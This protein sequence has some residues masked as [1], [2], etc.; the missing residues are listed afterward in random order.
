MKR[1]TIVAVLNNFFRMYFNPRPR[2]EGDARRSSAGFT[3]ADFN[4]RPREEGDR[5]TAMLK[6][7][8]DDFNPRP[9]EEGDSVLDA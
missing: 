6:D 3:F 1:A 7:A 9:R 5:I 2:E 8:R 4:P